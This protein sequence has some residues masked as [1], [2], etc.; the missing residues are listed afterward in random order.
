M[1]LERPNAVARQLIGAVGTALMLVA[2]AVI[3]LALVNDHVG[4]ALVAL[5][6]GIVGAWLIRLSR[7]TSEAAIAEQRSELP[8]EEL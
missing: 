6:P 1:H 2:V 4:W 8:D 5:L 7:N 3:P